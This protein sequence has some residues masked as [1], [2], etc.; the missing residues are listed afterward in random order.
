MRGNAAV[1]RRER[2]VVVALGAFVVVLAVTAAVTAGVRLRGLPPSIPASGAGSGVVELSPDA[3]RHPQG[4]AVRDQLQRH[5]DSINQR[6]YAGWTTTVVDK[7][8]AR[9]PEPKW[10]SDYRSTQDGTIR[11]DRIDDA[12]TGALLVRIRFVSTQDVADA[13]DATPA[14]RLCWLSTL[15]MEGTPPRIGLTQGDGS[16]STA[17]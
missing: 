12:Q 7:R 15:P 1:S 17:C 6:D 13:P 4:G 8:A 11:I 2:L 16:V 9:S 14:P 10:R 3:A 5:F